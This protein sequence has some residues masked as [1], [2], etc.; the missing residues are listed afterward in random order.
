MKVNLAVKFYC[1]MNGKLV[2]HDVIDYGDIPIIEI[3]EEEEL[4]VASTVGGGVRRIQQTVSASKDTGYLNIRNAK[5]VAEANRLVCY[6]I[7]NIK[8]RPQ[9]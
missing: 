8:Q 1:L 6:Y 3:Q 7:K 4:Q 9:V 5:Q 2:G